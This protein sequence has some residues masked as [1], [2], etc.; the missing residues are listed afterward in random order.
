MIIGRIYFELNALKKQVLV[1]RHLISREHAARG[2]GSAVVMNRPQTLSL[3]IN[4]DDPL[5][6]QSI[7]PGFNLKAA[8]R[9]VDKLDS[10]MESQLDFAFDSELGYLTAC[11][12]NLGTG[13]RA[14]ALL[15]LP[16]LV[17]S[18]Q[19]NRVINGRISRGRAKTGARGQ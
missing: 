3:M 16:A 12:T 1:E 11:P 5:R 2:V 10:A 7:Q 14:S 19:I 8:H 18:D 15:H 6:I 13:M 4:E 9:A 17:L